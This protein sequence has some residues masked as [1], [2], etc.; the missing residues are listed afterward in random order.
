M[1]RSAEYVCWNVPALHGNHTSL[2]ASS[3][4][5]LSCRV[6]ESFEAVITEQRFVM[7]VAIMFG[8]PSVQQHH[9]RYAEQFLYTPG[10]AQDSFAQ[11]S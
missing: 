5:E 2:K 1:W 9:S 7:C 3:E 8:T 6:S 10:R 4:F 11:Q